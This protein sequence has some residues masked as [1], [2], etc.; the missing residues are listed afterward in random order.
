[1]ENAKPTFILANSIVLYFVYV[2]HITEKKMVHK[3]NPGNCPTFPTCPIF[4]TIDR[5][6]YVLK[7]NAGPDSYTS[8]SQVLIFECASESPQELIR[9]QIAGSCPRVSDSVGFRCSPRICI[10]NSS[11]VTLMLLVLEPH[12]RNH[13]CTLISQCT[14]LHLSFQEEKASFHS[15][16][17]TVY[18][19]RTNAAACWVPYTRQ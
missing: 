18:W 15:N 16:S 3:C 6:V 11:H 19:P 13:Q 12:S 8:G 2:K 1:M 5:S 17:A 7:S 10:S 4:K 9:T 14:S